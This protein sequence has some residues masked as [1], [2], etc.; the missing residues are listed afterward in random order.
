MKK[1]HI[2]IRYAV[3]L[4]FF[5]LMPSIFTTAF[6]GVKYIFNA[7]GQGKIVQFTAFIAVLTTVALFNIV[8]GRFFCG[9]AC[10]LGSAELKN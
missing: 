10:S 4:L 3:Q 5:I 1:I 7:V 2:Y 6:S 9:F 8:F